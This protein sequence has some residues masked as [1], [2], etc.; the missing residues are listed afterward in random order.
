MANLKVKIAGM[1]FENPLIIAAGPPSRNYETIKRMVEGGAGGVVTKTISVK[2]ADVPRPCMAAFKESFINTELWSEHSPEHWLKEEYGKISTLPVPIIVGLGYTA[3]ELTELIPKTEP[4]ADA[5]ELSTHYVGRDLTPVLNTVT[6]ARK[7]TKKPIIVKVSP[8]VPDLAELGKKLEEVGVDALAAINSVGP[9]LRID[10]KTGLP[11]MGSDTGYGWISGPAIK[12][13]ALRHVFELSR[14][15]SIP[16]IGVGG[17]SSGEDVVEMFMAGA[18]AVQICTQAILEGPK[19]FKRIAQ[20]TSKWLDEHG[21][22]SLDDIKGLTAKKWSSRKEPLVK[23]TPSVDE[24]KCIGCHRCE[25]SCVYYAIKVGSSGKAGV[26]PDACFG[27][28][29]CYTRCPVGAITLS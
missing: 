3:K 16:V 5:F 1:E 10:L 7:A 21:Y 26:T 8:G 13:I 24:E 22:S 25:E 19:A 6:A 4:F 2:A 15:V 17:V 9:A 28:G 27:C 14:A 12:G 18:S 11:Y 29:L 23:V 20:E